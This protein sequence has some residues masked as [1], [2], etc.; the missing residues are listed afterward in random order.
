MKFNDPEVI[1]RVLR[2]YRC[3][4]IVGASNNPLRPSNGVMKHLMELGYKTI[5]INPNESEVL[6][7]PCYATLSAAT[8]HHRI[9]VVDVFRRPNT[10]VPLA[11]EAVTIGAK[12]IWFQL[13]VINHEAAEIAE[14]GGLSVVM[15][16]CPR[17]EIPRL[18][19]PG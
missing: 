7:Q 2:D 12:A 14:A 18:A 3:W 8:T 17:I 1:K 6:S 15:D 9:E 13:G 10:V 5:P 16:S 4:A 11:E 19:P